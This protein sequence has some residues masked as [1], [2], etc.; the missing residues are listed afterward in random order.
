MT[1]Q[2]RDDAMRT[3][4]G[5]AVLIGTAVAMFT[6]AA[7]AAAAPV[8]TSSAPGSPG[9]TQ[10]A[11][12]LRVA[13]TASGGTW[14]KAEEVPGIAALNTGGFAQL[15]SVSCGSAGNCGAGGQYANSAGEQAF[16]ASQSNGSWRK[17]V[18]V[19]GTAALNKN[20][21]A[22]TISVSCPSAGNCSAGGNYTDGFGL[23]GH[24]QAFV[25]SETNGIWGKAQEV[26]GTAALNQANGATTSVSCASAGNCSAGGFYT[27]SSGGIRAF[28]VSERNGTWGKAEE[29]P[30][31]AALGQGEFVIGRNTSVSC[32]SA[33]NCSASGG[34]L[35]SADH[36]QAFVANQ[37]N[38]IWRKA[39][40]VPGTAALNQGGEADINSLSCASVGNCSAGGSYADASGH[41]QAFVVSEKNGT[42]RKAIEAPGTAALNTGGKAAINSVSCASAGNCSAGGSYTDNSGHAQAFVT[43]KVNGT[44]G[45]AHEVPGT[46]ALNQG[47]NAGIFS[48]SCASAGNCSAGGSYTDSSGHVQA[49]VAG[50]VNG[51]WGK[52]EEVPG[53]AALNT[54]GQA[55]INSVSCGSA[56]HCSAGGHYSDSSG[57]QAFVVSET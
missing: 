46:A 16:V 47:G 32:A 3:A 1:G 57:L 55:A 7:A 22:A 11:A 18:E 29:V 15:L 5:V 49:F 40:E 53:T 51:T 9:G 37:V 41:P 56:A 36:D 17:A 13:D 24:S 44:W 25:V 8:P 14:G 23:D 38:G 12:G 10:V 28:V 48:V 26:P 2:G 21:Q 6:P 45:T 43:S 20:G 34:Y 42:W 52:A 27:D 4:F 31:L 54:G 30:G 50:Q 33:G 35:D 19:P 39:E